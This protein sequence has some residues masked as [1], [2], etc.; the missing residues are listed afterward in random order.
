MTNGPLHFMQGRLKQGSGTLN[1]SHPQDLIQTDSLVFCHFG[2]QKLKQ[3][4]E[5][6]IL[7]YSSC[8]SIPKALPNPI[9]IKLY[10]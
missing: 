7:G 10:C 9:T 8:G 5:K 4:K 3:Q 2:A 1:R 6:T